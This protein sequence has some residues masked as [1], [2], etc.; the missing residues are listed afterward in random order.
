MSFERELSALIN[1][2][3]KESKSNTP[4][5]VLAEYLKNCLLAFEKAVREREG[6]RDCNDSDWQ[7]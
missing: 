2:Y 3:N 4:D 5:F 6:Y 1:R 7:H